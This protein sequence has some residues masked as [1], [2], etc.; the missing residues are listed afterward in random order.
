MCRDTD[1][2]HRRSYDSIGVFFQASCSWLSE[3]LFGQSFSVTPPVEALRVF[4]C[5]ESFSVVQSIRNIETYLLGGVLPF[6]WMHQ[7]LKGAPWVGSCSVVQCIRH[8]IGQPLYCLAASLRCGEREAMVMA[9]PPTH[10]S[11]VSPCFYGCLAF[12][13]LHFLPQSPPS[14]PLNPCL[15][16][17]QPM[18]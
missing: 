8:L 4:P 3:G 18:P 15:R 13:H 10:D 6:G 17:Q 5:L 7:S 2:P 16:S 9:P 12:L 11:A 14:H 1:C